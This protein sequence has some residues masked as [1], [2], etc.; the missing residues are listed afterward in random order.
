M[1][2][3]HAGQRAQD[4]RVGAEPAQPL[5][6]VFPVWRS[7]GADKPQSRG[8]LPGGRWGWKRRDKRKMHGESVWLMGRA[9]VANGGKGT[10]RSSRPHAEA[11]RM[12]QKELLLQPRLMQ[13]L[14]ADGIQ[15]GALA[16]ITLGF[17]F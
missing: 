17:A 11:F 9:R 16:E 1:S 2:Y 10:Q 3:P 6:T 12:S 8:L 14:R 13:D 4:W 15:F 7:H 5:C